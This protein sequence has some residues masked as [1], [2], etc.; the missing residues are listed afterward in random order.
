MRYSRGGLGCENGLVLSRF[1]LVR[2]P[3]CRFHVNLVHNRDFYPKDFSS[4]LAIVGQ[5]FAV[6]VCLGSWKN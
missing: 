4:A 2:V 6:I 3:T 1:D 5:Q